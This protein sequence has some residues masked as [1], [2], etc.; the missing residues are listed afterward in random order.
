MQHKFRTS[1]LRENKKRVF[2]PTPPWTRGSVVASRG[3]RSNCSPSRRLGCLTE[4]AV[5]REVHPL[6]GRQQ[7][8][9]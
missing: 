8:Q 5:L 4:V 3:T 6:Q 1:E 9:A 7:G 2:F